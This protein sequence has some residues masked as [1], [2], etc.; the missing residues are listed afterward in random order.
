ML[1]ARSGSTAAAREQMTEEQFG[2]VLDTIYDAAADPDLWSEALEGLSRF[3]G[4]RIATLIDR[5]I[6]MSQGRGVAV[7]VDAASQVEFFSVWGARNP[8]SATAGDAKRD[9]HRPGYPSQAEADDERLLQW[10]HAPTRHAFAAAFH[11]AERSGLSP[12]DFDHGS[13]IDG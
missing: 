5:N 9:R 4:Y 12:V 3:F 8:S 13:A 7:G 11:A 10:I 2:R 6:E 1:E